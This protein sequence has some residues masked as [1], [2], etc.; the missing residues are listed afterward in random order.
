MEMK[1]WKNNELDDA[2]IIKAL[3][4]AVKD[5]EDRQ[6]QVKYRQEH[7]DKLKDYRYEESAERNETNERQERRDRI[8]VDNWVDN[9][10]YEYKVV[11]GK[12]FKRRK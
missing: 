12:I 4:Q 3:N 10:D 8:Q 7:I 9:L 11:N 1:F 5:Y 6:G 2:A